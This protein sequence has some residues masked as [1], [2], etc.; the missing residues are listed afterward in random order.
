MI[1]E[2]ICWQ[3]SVFGCLFYFRSKEKDINALLD[4]IYGHLTENGI[5]VLDSKNIPI[6]ESNRFYHRRTQRENVDLT[7]LVYKRIIGMVQ[8]S[9]Y[10]YFINRGIEKNFYIDEE[11]VRFYSLQELVKLN[12]G[13]FKLMDTYG[14]FHGNAY[15]DNHSE[16]MITV[17]EK[18]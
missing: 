8:N 11:F 3:G 7:L 15:V 9:Q 14:D 17:W 6:L 10:F 1:V 16:R 13:R 2:N 18:V 5:L 4:N 12:E